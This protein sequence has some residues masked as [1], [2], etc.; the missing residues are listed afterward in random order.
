MELNILD[1]CFGLGYNTFCTILYMLENNIASKVNFFSP[2]LDEGLIRKLHNFDFPKSFLKIKNIIEAVSKNQFYEDDQFKIEVYIGDARKY[3]KNN[4]N[5]HIVYQDAFS[6]DVNKELW[7]K[8]YFDDL[9]L[10]MAKK[11]IITTYS[12]ATPVRLSM[13]Y[14]GLYIYEHKYDGKRKA[15]IAFTNKMDAYLGLKFID[16]DKKLLNNQ[17]ATVYFD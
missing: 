13:W 10:S 11:S 7:T 8:E 3:I 15:T 17:D 6:S 4:N 16:M 5:I 2:E 14:N 1:I 9:K 12:I